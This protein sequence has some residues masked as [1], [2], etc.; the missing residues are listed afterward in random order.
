MTFKNY[1]E[2]AVSKKMEFNGITIIPVLNYI[3]GDMKIPARVWSDEDSSGNYLSNDIR[4][5]GTEKLV[6]SDMYVDLKFS[7]RGKGAGV[8][9]IIRWVTLGGKSGYQDIFVGSWNEEAKKW[10]IEKEKE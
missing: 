10:D 7:K 6:F 2:E 3:K 9:A 8:R 5:S 4:T 1:L